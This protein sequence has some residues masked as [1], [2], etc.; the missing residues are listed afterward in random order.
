MQSN[1]PFY[2][3]PTGRRDGRVSDISRA[4]NLPDVDDSIQLLKSKFRQK[5]LSNKDLVLLSGIYIDIYITNL[6]PQ[7]L[8]PLLPFS[9]SCAYH[10]N[11]CMLLHKDKTVQLHKRRRRGSCDQPSLPPET[12]GQVPVPGRHQCPVTA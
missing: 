9:F 1:G 10:W 8:N 3:V 12:K 6:P 11:Y 5:G 7:K 2:Q 4:A